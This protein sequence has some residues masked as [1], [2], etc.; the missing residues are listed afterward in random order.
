MLTEWV[1]KP[2]HKAHM[3]PKADTFSLRSNKW[4][5]KVLVCEHHWERILWFLWM[6]S[7]TQGLRWRRLI[8]CYSFGV[9][10]R[11]ILKHGVFTHVRLWAVKWMVFPSRAWEL[12]P[13]KEPV[14]PDSG[15]S[16]IRQS[17]TALFHLSTGNIRCWRPE[18]EVQL[19]I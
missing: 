14:F 17:T 1:R 6:P 12:Q 18:M 10:G 4:F 13:R 16:R 8:F 3:E 19:Q 9:C 2:M 15:T 11:I 7:Y 5:G